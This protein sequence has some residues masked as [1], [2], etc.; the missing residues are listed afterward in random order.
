MRLLQSF[1]ATTNMICAALV[2]LYTSQTKCFAAGIVTDRPDQTES[3]ASVPSG[4][5]QVETGWTH[6]RDETGG[7]ES[8][9]NGFAQTLLRIGLLERV[10]LRIGWDGYG[11]VNPGSAQPTI[12]GATDA[13]IGGK[14]ELWQERRGRPQAAALFSF[15]LPVGSKDLTSDRV[16]PKVRLSLSHTLSESVS[17]GYNIGVEASSE[18]ASDGSTHTPVYSIYTLALGSDLAGSLGGFAELFGELRTDESD[19]PSNSFDGGLTYL[20][21]ET[22]QLDVAGG[23]GLSS[24]ADDWFVTVGL[25]ALFLTR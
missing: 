16:D 6:S 12:T 8:T 21:G 5:F 4:G 3:S 15:T 7:I 22:V 10:E 25:S 18:F 9:T 14:I 24:A 23:V 2:V 13:S 11:R 17:L 1:T 20:F 19:A